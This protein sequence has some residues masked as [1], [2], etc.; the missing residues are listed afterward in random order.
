MSAN[1]QD[2]A[3][4]GRP[5][6][7]SRMALL[8]GLIAFGASLVGIA[9]RMDATVASFWPANALLLGMFIRWPKTAG[10]LSWPAALVGMVLADV[11][12]GT[13]LDVSLG[14]A[15]ANVAGMSLGYLLLSS[16][17]PE[18]RRLQHRMS[19]LVLAGSLAAA[20]LVATL[21]G[22]WLAPEFL[23]E[24]RRTSLGIW[25]V[26]RF[27]NYVLLVP[28]ILLVTWPPA[29]TRRAWLWSGDIRRTIKR[30]LP[31]LAVLASMTIIF[32]LD[33]HGAF[34]VPIL[35]LAWCALEYG[36][37]GTALAS[38]GVGLAAML[39]QQAGWLSGSIAQSATDELVA[40]RLGAAMLTLGALT[41]ARTDEDRR[42]LIDKLQAIADRDSLTE[43]YNRRAFEARFDEAVM[44]TA[45]EIRSLVLGV[46]DL[47]NFKELNDAHG[48]TA[49][50]EALKVLAK[51]L[52]ESL[53][54]PG[55][56]GRI[57][58]DELAV[59]MMNES[60]ESARVL[61]DAVRDEY[62]HLTGD[63]IPG[64]S[65]FSFGLAI[66][67]DDRST[68]FA[69]LFRAAD[70]SLYAVK[71]GRGLIGAPETA[72]ATTDDRA[73]LHPRAGFESAEANAN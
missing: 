56:V 67:D 2:V 61:L 49:G 71:R 16:V 53:P 38:I 13:S 40:V 70:E 26:T 68:T 73:G 21:A 30:V 60:L 44:R 57:G 25:W 42:A 8:V 17:A 34:A 64:G 27:A 46:I 9:F 59:L 48:H 69:S 65:T 55:S 11:L 22:I 32:G 31:A 63:M 1:R 20:S 4:G 39:G 28:S 33:G 5:F 52:R 41:L 43:V 10:I 23:D 62:Q 6:L 12:V 37:T 24:D 14:L 18:H 7:D 45:I 47:D 29:E 36:M 19:L 50:D 66:W 51:L 3:E 35:A 15:V 72:S 54:P 58:G